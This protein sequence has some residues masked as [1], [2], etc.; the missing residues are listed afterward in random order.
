MSENPRSE[1]V[2]RFCEQEFGP[3]EPLSLV[4]IVPDGPQIAVHSCPAYGAD[5][6]TTLFT[7]GLSDRPMTVPD[8]PGA[9]A[10][11]FAELFVQLPANWNYREVRDLAQSWPLHWLRTIAKY[12]HRNDTW[13]GAPLTVISAGDPL[14]PG[15]GFDSWLLCSV[16]KIPAPDGEPTRLYRLFPLYPEERELEAEHGLESLL[17]AFGAHDLE[18]VVDPTRPNVAIP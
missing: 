18:L 16:H 5:G 11:R 14:G 8:E 12:P 6:V 1:A 10:Y 7:T 4:E 15:V 9:H 17:Q 3:V 13:L 2:I